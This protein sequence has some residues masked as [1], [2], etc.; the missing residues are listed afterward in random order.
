MDINK[1]N[2]LVVDDS[3]SVRNYMKMILERAKYRVFVAKD[4]Q[5][6]IDIYRKY[7]CID[8][9][10]TDIYMPRKTGGDLI[11]E[12]KKE[13]NNIKI[14]AFSDGGKYNFSNESGECESIGATYFIKKENINNELVDLVNKI[15]SK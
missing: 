7:K 3:Q 5:E 12:L 13:N 1:K 11:M 8:L 4:G 9:V 14:I 15:F 6:A 2:I 10:V